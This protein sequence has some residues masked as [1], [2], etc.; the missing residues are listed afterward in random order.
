MPRAAGARPPG[1]LNAIKRRRPRAPPAR[2]SAERDHQARRQ[3]RLSKSY[4]ATRRQ[5][6]SSSPAAPREAGEAG[7]IAA[8]LRHTYGANHL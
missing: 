5:A 1:A 4:G 6:P 7:S 8:A 2:L 3:V